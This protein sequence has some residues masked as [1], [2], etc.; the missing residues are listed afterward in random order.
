MN[1][2]L[3]SKALLLVCPAYAIIYFGIHRLMDHEPVGNT[4]V[5][6]LLSTVIFGVIFYLAT[7]KILN[8]RNR[9]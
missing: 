4:L 1:R 7:N 8:N 9:N 5:K 2:S 6:A 3:T